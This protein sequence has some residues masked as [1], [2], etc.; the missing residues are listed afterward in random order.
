LDMEAASSIRDVLLDAFSRQPQVTL[1]LSAVESCDTA[2]LQVLL[3]AQ[4]S[5]ESMGKPFRIAPLSRAVLETAEA[6]GFS[7]ANKAA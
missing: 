2:A 7:I 5:A 3:A 4:K 1:D 6:L